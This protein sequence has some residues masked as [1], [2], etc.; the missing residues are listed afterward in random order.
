MLVRRDH[1]D[2]L[3]YVTGFPTD[4]TKMV[5]SSNNHPQFQEKTLWFSVA[6]FD[7]VYRIYMCDVHPDNNTIQWGMAFRNMATNQ[8]TVDRVVAE[9]WLADLNVPER[10][11]NCS[12]IVFDLLPNTHDHGGTFQGPYDDANP[13]FSFGE[14]DWDQ[15]INFNGD[16]RYFYDIL[17]NGYYGSTETLVGM[18]FEWAQEFY[19]TFWDVVGGGLVEPVLGN[20]LFFYEDEEAQALHHENAAHQQF[21]LTFL[22]SLVGNC[23][24]FKLYLSMVTCPRSPQY[25]E[26]LN[27]PE[28]ERIINRLSNNNLGN[29]SR[30]H[31]FNDIDRLDMVEAFKNIANI[32]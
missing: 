6:G 21:N 22:K 12:K 20:G 17:V 9:N 10:I 1:V 3:R 5:F 8:W 27:G 16:D 31:K 15:N 14:E 25:N 24:N 19:D 2:S 23:D 28:H 7:K 30:K 32:K 4:D 18:H 13:G 26:M 29:L 11:D